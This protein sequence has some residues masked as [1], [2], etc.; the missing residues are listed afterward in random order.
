MKRTILAAALALAFSSASNVA[1][2]SA[3]DE[4]G[5]YQYQGIVGLPIDVINIEALPQPN[6]VHD[7]RRGGLEKDLNWK[8]LTILVGPDDR[9]AAVFCG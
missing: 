1:T 8:R 4:C 6:R 9:I 2:A 3:V 7:I 5:A